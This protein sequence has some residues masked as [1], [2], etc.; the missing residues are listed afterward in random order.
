MKFSHANYSISVN[1][2]CQKIT[3]QKNGN[4]KEINLYLYNVTGSIYLRNIINC[5]TYG[6]KNSS[7]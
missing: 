5:H 2:S 4:K 1:R 3:K 7:G 6:M